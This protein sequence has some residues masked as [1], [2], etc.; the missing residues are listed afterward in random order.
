MS[1]QRI[2]YGAIPGFSLAADVREIAAFYGMSSRCVRL[3]RG[4]YFAAHAR[5]ALFWK[6]TTQRACTPER[7]GQMLDVAPKTVREGVDLHAKRIAEFQSISLGAP[8]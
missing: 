8:A 7:V 2:P 5:H 1:A 6:L 3:G 4:H